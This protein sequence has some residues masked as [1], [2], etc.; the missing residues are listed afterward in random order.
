LRQTQHLVFDKNS[1]LRISPGL[2]KGDE[3]HAIGFLSGFLN[4]TAT[5]AGSA[6]ADAFGRTLHDGMHGLQI[7]IPASRGD[8]VGMTDFVAEPG[9]APA[10]FTYFRHGDFAP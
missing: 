3:F 10:N 6:H 9:A 2:P 1:R 8:I 7:E 4:F 5:N